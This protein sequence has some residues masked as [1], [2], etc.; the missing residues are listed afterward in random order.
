MTGYRYPLAS[1]R[2]DYIQAGV[3]TTITGALMISAFSTPVMFFFIGPLFA[4]FAGFGVKTW[5]KHL[6]MIEIEPDGLKIYG[7]RRRRVDWSSVTGAKLRFFT[8]K[9]DR[10]A[11][12]MELTLLTNSRKIKI[13]S[14]IDGFNEIAE[15][16]A[17]IVES[18]DIK[19]DV[20]SVENFNA[21]GIQ[22]KSPGLPEAAKKF[23]KIKPWQDDMK[24]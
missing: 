10:D 20:T 12:W 4:L 17:R 5:L 18:K 3:G 19:I 13:E 21:I 1:L 24:M 23:D 7:L 16:V 15:A 22:T 11:G 8:I 9:R 2:G 14:T 6:T